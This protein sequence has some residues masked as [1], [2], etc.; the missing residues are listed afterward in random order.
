MNFGP[1]TKPNQ[2]IHQ[3][4]P[5]RLCKEMR[6]WKTT[7]QCGSITAHLASSIVCCNPQ[8]RTFLCMFTRNCNFPVWTQKSHMLKH[9]ITLSSTC[10]GLG[11]RE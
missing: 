11:T 10:L 4:Y 8:D 2:R 7:N 9:A 3:H 1:E 6:I 5:W